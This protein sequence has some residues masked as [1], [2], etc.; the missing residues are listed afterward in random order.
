M[1]FLK[2]FKGSE[3]ASSSRENGPKRGSIGQSATEIR[4]FP[5]ETKTLAREPRR[6]AS[7]KL[8]ALVPSHFNLE[9][10]RPQLPGNE[11]TISL[12]VVSNTVKNSIRRRE[13]TFVHQTRQINP[14]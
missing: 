11:Q 7:S 10:F 9:Q 13:L 3:K 8:V 1:Y 6:N 4:E 12:R 14:A 5:R 2:F